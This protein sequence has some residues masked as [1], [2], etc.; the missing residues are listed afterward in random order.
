MMQ[1]RIRRFR[2]AVGF[3]T[4]RH[5]YSPEL[6]EEAVAIAR[7]LPQ[8]VSRTARELGVPVVTLYAWLRSVPAAMR[9]VSVV[10]AP[11][12]VPAANLVVITAAGFRVEG[13]DVSSAAALLKALS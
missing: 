4:G 12:P 9:P 13:L 7:A 6:R 5:R 8:P 3:K 10:P 1:T 2:K 11:V